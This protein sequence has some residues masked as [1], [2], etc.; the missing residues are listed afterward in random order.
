MPIA[1]YSLLGGVRIDVIGAAPSIPRITSAVPRE[2][3][4]TRTYSVARGQRGIHL[5]FKVRDDDVLE[6]L[7]ALVD[8]TGREPVFFDSAQRP[9]WTGY[10][11]LG[12]LEGD[13]ETHASTNTTWSLQ[14]HEAS[15]ATTF[16]TIA[17]QAKPTRDGI[18]YWNAGTAA[19]ASSARG[20]LLSGTASAQNIAATFTA[21]SDATTDPG[22]DTTAFTTG[23]KL[24]IVAWLTLTGFSD[25]SANQLMG[26][27]MGSAT[28]TLDKTTTAQNNIAI[29]ADST[30]LVHLVTA[31][32]AAV[33]ATATSFT[34]VSGTR[35]K[36]RMD[37][38]V[39]T[40][41][42]LI[43]NDTSTLSVATTLPTNVNTVHAGWGTSGAVATKSVLVQDVAWKFT[44]SA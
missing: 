19:P 38:T 32:G 14:L 43:V 7:L 36:V 31:S 18:L 9:V 44:P 13:D 3:G 27:R 35:F 42:N 37:F 23:D 1:T 39:G 28:A 8:G 30:G 26:I 33:T 17:S 15:V 16:D 22:A 4:R 41:V 40:G 6:Q 34:A 25:L 24:S 29:G 20:T 2:R 11:V 21:E 10:Y 5:R 12:D